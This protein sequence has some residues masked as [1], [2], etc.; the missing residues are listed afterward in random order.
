VVLSIDSTITGDKLTQVKEAAART[1]G[2][3]RIEAHNGTLTTDIIGGE[4]V[5]SV[6]S[7]C[8]LGFNVQTSADDY[9]FLTA[10]HCIKDTGEWYGDSG[11]TDV[12]GTVVGKSFPGDDYGLVRYEPGKEGYGHVK[13][14][15]SW[16]DL[17]ASA[18]A[19]VGQDVMRTGATTGTHSGTVTA[20]NATANY[21]AGP[22]YGLIVTDMCAEGG[23][24]GGP[25]YADN[26]ALA[27]HSGSSHTG[28]CENDIYSY[29]QPVVEALA[30]YDAWVY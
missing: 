18:E 2:A 25:V 21:A 23:D 6:S 24:S 26:F 27:L 29:H 16:R 22:V 5:W 4:A 19:Y 10:G 13:V 17:T 7:W 8:S 12:I 15:N 1:N 28:A 14:D 3:V 30:A 9:Y 20:L 11:R